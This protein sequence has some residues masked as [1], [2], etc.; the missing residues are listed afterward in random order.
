MC[1]NLDIDV[2]EMS[3]I[4]ELHIHCMRARCIRLFQVIYVSEF[5]HIHPSDWSELQEFES[6]SLALKEGIRVESIKL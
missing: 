6:S 3:V 1:T 5:L 2:S 4:C